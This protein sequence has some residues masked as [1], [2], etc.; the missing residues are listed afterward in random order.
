[1][2]GISKARETLGAVLP[3]RIR[4]QKSSPSPKNTKSSNTSQSLSP[5]EKL[6]RAIGA[7]KPPEEPKPLSMKEAGELRYTMY[8]ALREIWR[9]ADEGISLSNKA[10]A[11]AHIWR[12]IDQEETY[13]IVDALIKAGMA[14][15]YVAQAVRG[16]SEA[17]HHLEVGLI[18][19]PRFIETWKFYVQHGIGFSVPGVA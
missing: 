7:D 11:E 10:Q 17:Y 2:R 16:V 1:M 4:S 5:E 12:K 8:K 14:N 18:L 15:P 6:R 9:Y 19:V 3:P 13:V